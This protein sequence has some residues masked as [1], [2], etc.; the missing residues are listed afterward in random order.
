VAGEERSGDS[1]LLDYLEV[2]LIQI[3]WTSFVPDYLMRFGLPTNRE[4]RCLQIH[5]FISSTILVRFPAAGSF[6]GFA[7]M[8]SSG[9]SAAFS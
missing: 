1:T 4:I 6:L 9:R 3:N 8:G 7:S 2:E 5:Q